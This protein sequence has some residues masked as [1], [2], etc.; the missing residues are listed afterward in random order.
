MSKRLTPFLF[1]VPI[2]T[3]LSVTFVGR[4]CTTLFYELFTGGLFEHKR[5]RGKQVT[6]EDEQR[7]D[8]G[9]EP[10]PYSEPSSETN[11][12]FEAGIKSN[13]NSDIDFVSDDGTLVIRRTES[14][15]TGSDKMWKCHKCGKPVYF[16]ERKTSLGYDWHPEC[17]RCEECCKRLN[18]GQH[19]EHKGMPYCYIPCYGA[20][21]GPQ[22][23]GHGSRVES[24]KSFGKAKM[25]DSSQAVDR[26]LLETKVKEYNRYY[27]DKQ[28]SSII[29]CR[30]RNGKL[31]LEGQL[32]VYWDISN[33]LILKEDDDNRLS[34]SRRRST[35]RRSRAQSDDLSDDDQDGGPSETFDSEATL[36]DADSLNSSSSS[37]PEYEHASPDE[38]GRDYRTLPKGGIKSLA[39]TSNGTSSFDDEYVQLRHRSDMADVPDRMSVSSADIKPEDG[40]TLRKAKLR[41][42][43]V[44]RRRCSINGHYYNRETCV[45]TPETGSLTSVFVTSFVT[46]TEVINMLLDKF[47]V[48]NEAKDFALYVIHDNGEC[49][50]LAD[51][52]CPLVNR[53]LLGPN[54]EV[55][56]VYVM[57]KPLHEVS[58]EVAA[59]LNLSSI[60]LGMFL[61]KFEEEEQKEIDRIKAKFDNVRKYIRLRIKELEAGHK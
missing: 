40:V 4:I 11:L 17:L 10:E 50:R 27:E 45:F 24:H 26:L 36:N 32:R 38:L 60:E 9:R 6:F 37:S 18:P 5:S 47:K 55:S 3:F 29:D 7:G 12:T 15:E 16:A 8:G 59:F 57:T 20:L 61:K 1:L 22:L 19:A 51:S 21:F 13:F 42:S 14:P 44:L 34:V 39:T 33:K 31:I 46:T 48:M 28:Q 30:E 58:L 35:I 54:E 43:R 23:Y 25:A 49:K 41:R 53:V 56:K 2:W 52:E